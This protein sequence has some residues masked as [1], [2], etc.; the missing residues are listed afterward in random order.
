MTLDGGTTAANESAE[1][2]AIDR[3]YLEVHR[4]KALEGVADLHAGTRMAL[5]NIAFDVVDALE[6]RLEARGSTID[7]AHLVE[8]GVARLEIMEV[9][10]ALR[11]EEDDVDVRRTLG[12]VDDLLRRI[13]NAIIAGARV[14]PLV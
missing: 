11:R 6:Q 8:I 14:S 10:G 5:G 2:E 7:A 3:A 9:D 4:L 13:E 12:R 1:V